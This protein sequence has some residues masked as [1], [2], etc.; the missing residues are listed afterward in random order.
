VRAV[1]KTRE[2]EKYA[3]DYIFAYIAIVVASAL[4]WGGYGSLLGMVLCVVLLSAQFG[5]V[6]KRATIKKR[7][8][9]IITGVMAVI[10]IAI[11]IIY[12]YWVNG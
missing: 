11:T 7:L 10:A 8:F 1:A 12:I 9:N 2:D 5:S 4:S 6:Q 3:M